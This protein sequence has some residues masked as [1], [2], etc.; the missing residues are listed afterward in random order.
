MPVHEITTE[1]A[2][3]IAR[4]RL[5][6]P[7]AE[8]RVHQQAWGVIVEVLRHGRTVALSGFDRHGGIRSGWSRLP[9][10]A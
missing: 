2:R 9:A 7:D 8:V 4:L 6:W 3:F 10:A 1:Q 5:A